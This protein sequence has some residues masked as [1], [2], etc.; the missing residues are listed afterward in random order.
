MSVGERGKGVPFQSGTPGWAMGRFLGLGQS[1][2]LGPFSIFQIFSL[3]CF[4]IKF[5]QKLQN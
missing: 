4:Y 5:L 3:F 2:A 1:F